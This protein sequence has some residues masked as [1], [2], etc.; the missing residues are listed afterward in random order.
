MVQASESLFPCLV[1]A[2]VVQHSH[3]RGHLRAY[4][5]SR[6]RRL[7]LKAC[8][9]ARSINPLFQTVSHSDGSSPSV[10]HR[11]LGWL[12]GTD[13]GREAHSMGCSCTY[14][15]S[16]T[17]PYKS[18]E[19]PNHQLTFLHHLSFNRMTMRRVHNDTARSMIPSPKHR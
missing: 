17:S 1:C 18:S 8:R 14:C 3:L 6:I 7:R 15:M 11:Y 10:A 13:T 19:E 9:R 5:H 2:R 4:S 12:K 16:H